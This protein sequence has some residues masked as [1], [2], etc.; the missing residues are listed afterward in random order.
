LDEVD[1]AWAGFG[2]DGEELAGW[3]EIFF[4]ICLD[5]LVDLVL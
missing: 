2:L 5:V 4:G 1:V 3:G